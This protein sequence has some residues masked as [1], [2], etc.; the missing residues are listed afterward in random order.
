MNLAKLIFFVGLLVA[1]QLKAQLQERNFVHYT[2]A[3]GLSHNTVTGLAQDAR[4]YMWIT[5]AAGLN[6]FDGQRFL[7]FH[8]SNDSLSPASE[9]SSGSVW[10][11]KDLLALYNSGLHIINTKTN[12]R[13]NLFIPYY[14][15]QLQYKFNMIIAALGDEQRAV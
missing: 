14:R 7:Q 6:R 10:L 13:R 12:E 5:T 3:D 15:Q 2:T 9:F 11:N 1:Q 8:S 4:G